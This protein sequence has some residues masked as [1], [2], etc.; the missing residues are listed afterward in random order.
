VPS[1]FPPR[2][3]QRRRPGDRA[4][5]QSG[6][7]QRI[8][9]SAA[10]KE[11]GRAW[12]DNLE[13]VAAA[14]KT[15]QCGCSAST[16]GF[17]TAHSAVSAAAVACGASGA[18]PPPIRPL[19]KP[20]GPGGFKR[21]RPKCG[22]HDAAAM[23]DANSSAVNVCGP[24]QSPAGA[25]G[26]GACST[27]PTFPPLPGCMRSAR[28]PAR[29]PLASRA[30]G[31]IRSDVGPMPGE[32]GGA[33]AVAAERLQ[34][35]VTPVGPRAPLAAASAQRSGFRPPRKTQPPRASP[36][37]PAPLHT[38]ARPVYGR[39]APQPRPTPPPRPAV[40]S[41]GTGA[42]SRCNCPTVAPWSARPCPSCC[43]LCG[44]CLE[45]PS[46]TQV[47]H[48]PGCQ[49]DSAGMLRVHGDGRSAV[50]PRQQVVPRGGVG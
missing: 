37:L 26:G 48:M 44:G 20:G 21:P 39:S 10:A 22:G 5:F 9:L 29:T 27:G 33:G 16:G 31:L 11:R 45:D 19:H 42:R 34:S 40:S 4:M 17:E 24:I 18:A 49:N 43:S 8:E 15:F 30:S 7:G 36:A 3:R 28:S 38:P 32:S 25:T 13:D 50:P 35:R 6:G 2:A 12:M 23:A 47:M 46:R 1:A 14:H 41:A